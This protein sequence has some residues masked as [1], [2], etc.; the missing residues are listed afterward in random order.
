MK[1]L[2]KHDPFAKKI[3][4]KRKRNIWLLVA[5]LVS[6]ATFIAFII[7]VPPNSVIQ[8]IWLSISILPIFF[9]LLSLV[10][11]FMASYI[12]K[13]VKHGILLFLFVLIYLIFRLNN[14]THPFFLILLIAL[15]LTLELLVSYRKE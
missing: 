13:S 9:L 8:I 7:L 2:F 11:F 3:L 14:L 1:F 12:F 4:H 5:S 10:L 15:F 6:L